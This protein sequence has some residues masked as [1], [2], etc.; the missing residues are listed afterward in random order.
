MISGQVGSDCRYHLKR[1]KNQYCKKCG[2]AWLIQHL[3]QLGTSRQ[4]APCSLGFSTTA[5]PAQWGNAV[6]PPFYGFSQFPH[7]NSCYASTDELWQ[8]AAGGEPLQ[9]LSIMQTRIRSANKIKM[10]NKGDWG[11]LSPSFSPTKFYPQSPKNI[12][13][14]KKKQSTSATHAT[15]FFS[16]LLFRIKKL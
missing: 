8:K 3:W 5:V 10:W 2:D 15:N 13:T 14:A 16:F 12:E 11:D 4:R 9:Q 7:S 6:H 1:K